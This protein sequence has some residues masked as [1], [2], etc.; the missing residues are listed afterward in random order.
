M[1]SPHVLKPLYEWHAQQCALAAER[2][3]NSSHRELLIKLAREWVEAAAA[4]E[5]TPGATPSGR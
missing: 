1:H 5:A 4:L 2:P 3:E